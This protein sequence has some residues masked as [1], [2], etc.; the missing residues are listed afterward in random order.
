MKFRQRYIIEFKPKLDK[1]VTSVNTG[2]KNGELRSYK[3][4]K[5][6]YFKSFENNFTVS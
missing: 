2:S 3:K 6:F 1:N 5:L 4:A